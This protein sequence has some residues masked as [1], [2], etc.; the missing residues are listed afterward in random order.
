M[1]SGLVLIASVH[2]FIDMP[3]I[4]IMGESTA[5][6]S[7]HFRSGIAPSGIRKSDP[8]ILFQS[9]TD[10]DDAVK[11]RNSFLHE[12][13]HAIDQF[14]AGHR[15]WPF[16][17]E[18]G[19]EWNCWRRTV[20]DTV[21]VRDLA[22]CSAKPERSSGANTLMNLL[23]YESAALRNR[24]LPEIWARSYAQYV[25]T[26]SSDTKGLEALAAVNDL[27]GLAVN[28]VPRQWTEVDFESVEKAIDDLFANLG[29][30]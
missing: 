4:L 23:E 20:L 30:R 5:G 16:Q 24:Q 8:H 3:T 21:H 18:T 14:A 9:L 7:A 10:Q 15:E 19:A 6:I 11:L 26:K 28:Q 25:L 27:P 29:M 13:G 2:H 22:Y 17:S 1:E 12:V